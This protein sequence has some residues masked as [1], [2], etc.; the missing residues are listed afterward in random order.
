MTSYERLL[1]E[2][3]W[4]TEYHCS[5]W[6]LGSAVVNLVIAL[7]FASHGSELWFFG[8]GLASLISYGRAIVATVRLDRLDKE[9]GA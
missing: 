9:L 3:S 5:R 7:S 2:T 1:A 6:F 4:H 8:F